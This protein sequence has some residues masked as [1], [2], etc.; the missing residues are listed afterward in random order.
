MNRSNRNSNA[1]SQ[2]NDSSTNRQSSILQF[3]REVLVFKL[4]ILEQRREKRRQSWYFIFNN[5]EDASGRDLLQ[6]MLNR[7]IRSHRA[8]TEESKAG[9][10]EAL[11][12]RIRSNLK[13]NKGRRYH[14]Y[15]DQAESHDELLNPIQV[16]TN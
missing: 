14:Y 4:N 13:F 5:E 7:T 1:S 16:I 3:L 11:M 15:D 12:R 8:S 2:S 9:D 6:V 10:E